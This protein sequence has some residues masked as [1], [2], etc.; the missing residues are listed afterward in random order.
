[1]SPKSLSE[2]LAQKAAIEKQIADAQREQRADAIAK[3]KALMAEYGLTLA[4]VSARAPVAPRKQPPAKVA[5]KFHNKA[6][7]ET[8]SGRG[9]KP[10]WLTAALASGRSLTEFEV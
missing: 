4:D 8:W 1:M 5:V 2:L 9:L 7:G 10:K 6:T 3:V